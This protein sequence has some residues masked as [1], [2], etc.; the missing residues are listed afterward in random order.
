MWSYCVTLDTHQSFSVLFLYVRLYIV[1]AVEGGV[2]VGLRLLLSVVALRM[3]QTL[4]LQPSII[5][6]QV[7]PS[8]FFRS[9]RSGDLVDVVFPSL[10]WSS[11]TSACSRRGDGRPCRKRR[12][13]R[14]TLH[15][16][17][18][19]HE[20]KCAPW[21]GLRGSMVRFPWTTRWLHLKS[22]SCEG[23]VPAA[24]T[25]QLP[26]S[27]SRKT[28]RCHGR[29]V[30]AQGDAPVCFVNFSS[31]MSQT[32]PSSA[33][34]KKWMQKERGASGRNAKYTKLQQC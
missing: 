25:L 20:H 8:C 1:G 19:L 17:N 12:C 11:N 29:T 22:W 3:L 5:V 9:F 7:I 16:K 31:E 15:I 28:I 2:V 6:L 27:P 30:C 23:A 13:W 34:K 24:S 18:H 33:C 21:R 26:R 14:G 4:L 32:Q 10:S